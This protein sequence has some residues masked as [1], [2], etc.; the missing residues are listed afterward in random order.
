M[1][2][3]IYIM[4]VLG[5]LRLNEDAAVPISTRMTVPFRNLCFYQ[6]LLLVLQ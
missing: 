2:P 4:A 1:V 6:D 3:E 5:D